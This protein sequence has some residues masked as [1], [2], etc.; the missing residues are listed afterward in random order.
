MAMLNEWLSLADGMIQRADTYRTSVQNPPGGRTWSGDTAGAIKAMADNDHT[1]I[2]NMSTAIKTMAQTALDSIYE[3]VILNLI[4]AIAMYNDLIAKHY[5]VDENL[6]VTPDFGTLDMSLAALS[7]LA[8]DCEAKSNALR[9]AAQTWWD[10]DQ[11]V[12]DQ[13]TADQGKL[14][15]NFD[16]TGGL[17]AADGA[18]DGSDLA[19]GN[20]SDEEKARL[21]AAASLPPDMA[22]ALANWQ[23]GQPPVVI[24]AE[25][26]AYLYQISQAL[27]GLP[28]DKIREIMNNLPPD[29]RA[30]LSRGLAL[31]SN[32][33]VRSGISNAEGAT[34]ATSGTFIPAAGSVNNLP[35]GI[36]EALTR[37]ASERVSV[38]DPT[39]AYGSDGSGFPVA[40]LLQ[41]SHVGELQDVAEI[42]RGAA[43]TGIPGGPE[44]P[45]MAVCRRVTPGM[46]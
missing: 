46:R 20:L 28:P 21:I 29:A 39:V 15:A 5:L 7:A 10:S 1:A 26:M 24:G 36:R 30:A 12:A 17:T 22:A 25:R 32:T 40:G 31:V 38:T 43:E 23:P 6:H 42:F 37:P 45:P 14:A 19:N 18:A 44:P 8:G 2:E 16:V 9:A 41:L 33:N 4:T 11:V 34:D 27:N 35:S 3:P 13:I